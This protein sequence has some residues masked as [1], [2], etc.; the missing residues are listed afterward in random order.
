VAWASNEEQP[1]R[2]D[3]P[4][5]LDV[6]LWRQKNSL[7]LHLVNFTNPMFMKGPIRE[8]IPAGPQRVSI[9]APREHVRE[10]KL[11]TAGRAVSFQ[12]RSGRIELEVP[13][14]ALHE[15]VALDLA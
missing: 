5:V 11:L 13:S 14:I 10:A 2:V 3:G 7:A 4:G 1:V 12:V 8:I 15:V 9:A 6:T